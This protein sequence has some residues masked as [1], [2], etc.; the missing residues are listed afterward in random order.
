MLLSA[1]VLVA[2]ASVP[3]MGQSDIIGKLTIGYQGWFSAPG[4]ASPRNQW[5]H[6]GNPPN[7]SKGRVTFELYPDMRE[8]QHTYATNLANLG[9]GQQARLFSS[10]DDQTV[11]LHFQWMQKYNLDTVELSVCFFEF[12]V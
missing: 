6:W 11:D 3:V 8:Y 12:N 9:N 10:W 5:V 1:L 4:D 7:I 2:F